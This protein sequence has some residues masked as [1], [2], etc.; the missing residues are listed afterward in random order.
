MSKI[1]KAIAAN[2]AKYRKQAGL[3]Q[4]QF[5]EHLSV[6]SQAV[7]KWECGQSVPDIDLFPEIASLLEIQP[8]MLLST[9]EMNEGNCE[10]IPPAITIALGIGGSASDRHILEHMIHEK[11]LS[12]DVTVTTTDKRT[13]NQY[14]AHIPAHTTSSAAILDLSPYISESLQKAIGHISKELR[15][16]SSVLFCPK[17][18]NTVSPNVSLNALQ[19]SNGHSYPLVDGVIDFGTREIV[20]ELW[21][22]AFRNYEH[23]VVEA[24]WPEL[25]VYNRG[26]IFSEEVKWREIEKFRPEIILDIAAGTGSGI[27][28][29]IERIHWN[30]TVILTDLSHRILAWDRQ[31]ITENLK[32]PHVRL[33]FLACDC[34][35]MPIRT[36]TIDCITTRGGFESMREKMKPGF[37]DAY[38]ILKNGGKAV[39][40]IPIRGDRLSQNTDQWMTLLHS[41]TDHDFPD[42][43]DYDCESNLMDA[44]EWKAFCDATGYMNTHR[45]SIYPEL[46]APDTEIFPFE[47]SVLRWTGLDVCVSE[48]G[49]Y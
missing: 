21:S 13:G 10:D 34:S 11:T 26:E 20:G 14:E 45:I 40:D 41:A 23:Y 28:Y 17:C 49:E 48:K 30:C 36:G 25:P 32:N 3:T 46:P 16:A 35:C 42:L 27:K 4:S 15:I 31:Y 9:Q 47:N 38:R 19:C 18:G 5:A 8:G 7:S 24:T 37:E 2:I 6:T 44:D 39:Y 1:K 12:L 22:L 43:P 29:L 33:L